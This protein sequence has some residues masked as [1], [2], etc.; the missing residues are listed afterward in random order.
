MLRIESGGAEDIKPIY[1]PDVI[2]SWFHPS[3]RRRSDNVCISYAYSCVISS[4]V[5][6]NQMICIP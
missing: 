3:R 5:Y 4:S 6:L 2:L 1:V